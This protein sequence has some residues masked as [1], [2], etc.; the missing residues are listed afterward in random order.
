LALTPG[1]RLGVYEV[2]TQI[3]AG[4]MGEVYRATD[5]NLKRSVA[6]KVL[7]ASVA[8]DADRLARFQREA[9]VLAALNHPNIGAIYGLEKT[10]DFTA[11]VMELVEGEDLSQRIT[12]GAIPIEEALPIA[13][14]IAEA[15]EA[16]H[17]QG[18][19]HRDLKPANI[20][21]RP[22]GTVKVLD[23]GLAKAIEPAAGSSPNMSMSP[24]MLSPAQMSGVGVILGTAAYM[25][26]E[27]ARGKA[28]DKRAD[29]WAF[30]VIVFEM[31]TGRRAF[32]G[33]E[34]SDVLAAVLRQDIDWAALPT[35]APRLRR[36]LERCLDRDPKSRLRDIGEAR[37]EIATIDAGAPESG[38]SSAVAAAPPA[39]AT[40]R[41]APLVIATAV[42]AIAA[43]FGLTRWLTSIATTTTSGAVA[44]VTI[45]L[46]DTDQLDSTG[47]W[48]LA[49][50]DDGARVA[51]VG[52]GD[53]KT[54]IYVRTLTESA[55]KV[56]EATEGGE[57]PFFSPDGQW[58]AFFAGSKLRKIAVGGAA[59]QTLADAPSGRG[60]AWGGDGYIYFAPTNSGGIWRVPEGGG[61]ATEV[62]R[63]DP[64]NGEISHRWPHVVAGTNTLLFAMWTG[65]GNDDDNV[66][67]QTIGAAGHHVLVKAG[68]APRYAATPGLLLYVHL[69]ELFA[70]PWR[71]PQTDLGR[72]VPVAMPERISGSAGSEK[73]GNY[74][75]SGN[76][77]LAYIAGGRARNATRLV[78]VDRAGKV[79]LA[80]LPERDY[81]N[82][83]V[84]SDGTRAIVQIREATI[85]L[86]V[87]DLSRNT[88]TPIGNRAGSSQSPVWTADGARVI[89]RGTR[90][91]FR[92]IYWRPV[93]GSGDEERLTTKPDVVQSPTSVSLDGHW[94]VFQENGAGETG[95]TGIWVMRLDGDRTPHHFFPAPA[96]ESDG[97]LSPD[98][99]WI[100]YEA[101]VS[102]R[103]EI[104]VAP[105]PGPGPRHQVSTDGGTEPLWSR[106]SRELFF[107]NG[108]RLMGVTV[109]PSAAFSASTP[110]L[111]HEG[112]FLKTVNSNTN[113]GITRD[114][115]RFLRIQ[116]VEPERAVTH[117]D[118]VLNWFA[119]LKQLVVRR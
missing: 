71:P 87:Y 32:A 17:E 105:F 95:G 91:G 51:Y 18:I 4:G 43:T 27:Q 70:V 103:Q 13:K 24:T 20:K 46:P 98:G 109:T 84:S 50:S 102:S 88:L 117:I 92:N 33:D 75:V 52:R 5:S 66:A 49:L 67:I 113:S 53:G 110:H 11:L 86:W 119:E 68:D 59:L 9:E 36:L 97:Q 3:G 7:P 73:P 61:T 54:Q 58:V 81:E 96:G 10:P 106:D 101:S 41:V 118:L 77:T 25:A 1:T 72:T 63:K 79:D 89:Y 37:V 8:G 55:P 47:L 42:V 60:C 31:L 64:A 111:V 99:R 16:A 80:P 12:R 39:A 114:G 21:V 115:T 112:R 45:A 29:I 23:F 26:P 78:W 65:P 108:A 44:H 90:K 38:I 69:G 2:V 93:D 19:I 14:Q 100:A 94:L 104:Y 76:G 56:L 57:S 62:T 6:I 40:R 30:G 15:L 74:A 22:D 107:Q 48:P 116:Q 28:V 82:A 83:T 85:A 34:I 35:T